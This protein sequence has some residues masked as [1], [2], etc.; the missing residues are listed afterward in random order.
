MGTL[1]GN[2]SGHSLYNKFLCFIAFRAKVSG[3]AS[4]NA[5]II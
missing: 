5:H 2:Y 3:L 1:G 4:A